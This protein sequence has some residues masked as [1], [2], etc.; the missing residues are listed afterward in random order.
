MM[1]VTYYW[2]DCWQN[3][4]K[5]SWQ[6]SIVLLAKMVDQ[7][8]LNKLVNTAVSVVSILANS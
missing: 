4:A 6:I 8:S 3:L 7:G 2:S 1:N 5:A